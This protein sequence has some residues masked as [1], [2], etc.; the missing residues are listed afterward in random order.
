MQVKDLSPDLILSNG[1]F[2]TL[3]ADSTIA[4]AVAI[5]DSYIVAVG[6]DAQVGAMAGPGTQHALYLQYQRAV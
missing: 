2:Y 6:T 1:R 3:D 4:Q 5:K